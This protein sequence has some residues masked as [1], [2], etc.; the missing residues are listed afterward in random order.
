M[1]MNVKLTCAVKSGSN[2]IEEV[3]LRSK[4][5][6]ASRHL[7]I[8]QFSVAFHRCLLLLRS[9]HHHHL[10]LL[11]LQ[12]G[13]S[14]ANVSSRVAEW[15]SLKCVQFAAILLAFVHVR[16]YSQHCRTSDC[17]VL[18]SSNFCAVSATWLTWLMALPTMT[19]VLALWQPTLWRVFLHFVRS[20][21]VKRDAW[22]IDIFVSSQSSRILSS[23]IF[24]AFLSTDVHVCN[25]VT[26]EI[27]RCQYGSKSSTFSNEDDLVQSSRYGSYEQNM[28]VFELA[29]NQQCPFLLTVL[30]VCPHFFFYPS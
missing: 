14:A 12:H 3:V 30:S 27:C 28:S 23:Y 29:T 21:Q 17:S 26:L 19:V 15:M 5:T 10:L 1:R 6:L 7:H 22:S 11:L 18:F 8:C 24:L 16:Q 13:T 4:Q 2:C 20:S 25:P 9:P